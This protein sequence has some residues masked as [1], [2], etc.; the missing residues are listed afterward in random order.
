MTANYTAAQP[1]LA[2]KSVTALPGT[3]FF[4]G[5]AYSNLDVPQKDSSMNALGSQGT[6]TT[7]VRMMP[8]NQSQPPAL[9]GT[10]DFTTP[11]GGGGVGPRKPGPGLGS[12]PLHGILGMTMRAVQI[13]QPQQ[14]TFRGSGNITM[15]EGGGSTRNSGPGP[16]Q[17]PLRG[18]TG[19]PIAT[20]LPQVPPET[21]FLVD[22]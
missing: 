5:P 12:R 1:Y 19:L 6:T 3:G 18:I 16:G 22:G 20:S 11:R 10:D 17:R 8:I 21:S 7:T 9:R 15:P 14:L 4:D 2:D 13:S